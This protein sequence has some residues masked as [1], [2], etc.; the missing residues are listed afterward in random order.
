MIEISTTT[1]NTWCA[2]P[3]RG[4]Q[5]MIGLEWDVA[6][7]IAYATFVLIRRPLAR[8]TGNIRTH[9]AGC[10]HANEFPF[11]IGHWKAYATRSQSFSA[12]SAARGISTN[13]AANYD[14]G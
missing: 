14:L 12:F 9:I 3:G 10:P 11:A 13:K 2:A 4:S 1:W 7:I 5:V 6:D 8:S